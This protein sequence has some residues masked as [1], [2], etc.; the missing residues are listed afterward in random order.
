MPSSLQ[1]CELSLKSYNSLCWMKYSKA[2]GCWVVSW[3]LWHF[4]NL[5]SFWSSSD[6]QHIPMDSLQEGA[7][8]IFCSSWVLEN[9]VLVWKG[10]CEVVGSDFVWAVSQSGQM[11]SICNSR[12]FPPQPHSANSASNQCFKLIPSSFPPILPSILISIPHF[13]ALP[14]IT[15]IKMYFYTLKK[16]KTTLFPTRAAVVRFQSRIQL[17]ISCVQGI[18]VDPALFQR[19]SFVWLTF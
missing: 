19:G 4:G 10:L 11:C 12:L 8:C 15:Q 6:S 7:P 5:S 16:P 9:A 14:K 13:S 1:Q 18:S 3:C 17:Q 2:A